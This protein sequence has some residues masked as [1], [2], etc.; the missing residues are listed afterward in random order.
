MEPNESPIVSPRLSARSAT[1]SR[2]STLQ[3]S[4]S[5]SPSEMAHVLCTP[6]FVRKPKWW[7][8]QGNIDYDPFCE[9]KAAAI[10]FILFVRDDVEIEERAA[11][12]LRSQPKK[13]RDIFRR[14]T[15]R[16]SALSPIDPDLQQYARAVELQTFRRGLLNTFEFLAENSKGGP[17]FNL[18]RET[19]VQARS[20]ESV[21]LGSDESLNRFNGQF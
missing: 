11:I 17:K 18:P 2:Q 5:A 16:F 1:A 7:G 19:Q 14:V 6:N 20:S 12:R 9:A 10:Q 15:R 3:E 8:T 13:R 4:R 21:S